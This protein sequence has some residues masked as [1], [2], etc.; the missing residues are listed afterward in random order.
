LAGL[1]AGL[2]YLFRLE[3]LI[4]PATGALVLTSRRWWHGGRMSWQ[5]GLQGC[6]FLG[7]C[8]LLT[9]TPYVLTIGKL[10]PRPSWGQVLQACELENQSISLAGSQHLL[11]SRMQD[12]VNGLRIEA[13]RLS[14]A[15][16][17]MAVSLAKAGHY[18]IWLLAGVGLCVIWRHRR[19]DLAVGV[20]CCLVIVD[21]L[22]LLR[23]GYAAGYLS[24]RHALVLVALACMP[25]GVGFR[26]LGKRFLPSVSRAWINGGL[27]LFCL[28]Y[29]LPK[30]LQPLHA[31]QEGHRQAG[32]YLASELTEKDE[33]IDPYHW[34]SFYAGRESAGAHR[35]DAMRSGD[36]R[37]FAVIDPHDAD[38]NRR[39]EWKKAGL[40]SDEASTLFFWPSVEH[41]KVLIKRSA[42]ERK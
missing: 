19:G 23:L 31:S 3:A 25:A 2:G 4:V 5:C 34:A 22:I 21:V 42:T 8:F 13:L 33:L 7:G 20:L 27:T 17:L 16:K 1:F 36:G 29:C 40:L 12:G 35:S 14:D 37:T 39:E 41:P 38:L 9:I 24:E 18:F 10:S 15:L 6:L 26:F 11:A 28:L 32:Y 30:A